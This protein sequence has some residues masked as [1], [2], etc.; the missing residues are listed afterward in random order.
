[1]VMGAFYLH[2]LTATIQVEEVGDYLLLTF[3]RIQVEEAV[4]YLL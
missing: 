3:V 1:M 4:V 2:L